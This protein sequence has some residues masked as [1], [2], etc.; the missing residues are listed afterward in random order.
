MTF[1]SDEAWLE[2]LDVRATDPTAIG[3]ALAARG[4]ALLVVSVDR[5]MVHC[6]CRHRLA[7][8]VWCVC[9]G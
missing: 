1:L 2:L 5:H 6:S 9:V 3:A 7:A 8:E 4:M